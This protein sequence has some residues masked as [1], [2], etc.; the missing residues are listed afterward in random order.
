MSLGIQNLYFVMIFQRYDN[1]SQGI[2]CTIPGTRFQVDD[3]R[4]SKKRRRRIKSERDVNKQK[5]KDLS[6]G[7]EQAFSHSITLAFFRTYEHRTSSRRCELLYT[8][9][10][11]LGLPFRKV[12]H[13]R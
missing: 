7:K 6:Q 10:C 4:R 8:T 13:R 12:K 2:Y 5:R 3:S 1:V 11:S 9:A